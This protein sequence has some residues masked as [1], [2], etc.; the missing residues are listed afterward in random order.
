MKDSPIFIFDEATSAIDTETEAALHQSLIEIGKKHT[1][2][3]I[4]HRL[5]TVRHANIIH[6]L[7]QGTI[8]ESGTH[9]ELIAYNKMYARLWQLQT[10]II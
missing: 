10:G 3:I 8:V 2:I 9:D 6:V 1:T 7:N 5:S 4:A